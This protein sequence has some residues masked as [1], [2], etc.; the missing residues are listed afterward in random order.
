MKLLVSNLVS[1]SRRS[2]SYTEYKCT[3]SNLFYINRSDRTSDPVLT[4]K[5][6]IL[7]TEFPVGFILIVTLFNFRDENKDF[8]N[9]SEVFKT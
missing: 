3:V 1:T 4:R 5:L 6:I 2:L 8:H 7:R 9:N